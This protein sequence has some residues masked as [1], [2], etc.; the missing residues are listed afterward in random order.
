MAVMN[1]FAPVTESW[2]QTQ[3]WVISKYCCLPEGILF[4]QVSLLNTSFFLLSLANRAVSRSALSVPHAPR[5]SLLLSFPLFC[6]AEAWSS[7]SPLSPC[8]QGVFS[9]LCPKITL[10]PELS[11]CCGQGA[12]S[13]H[14][15]SQMGNDCGVSDTL[16]VWDHLPIA[17]GPTSLPTDRTQKG[18]SF[19]A[20]HSSPCRAVASCF[21]PWNGSVLRKGSSKDVSTGWEI[22]LQGTVPVVGSSSFPAQDAQASVS[23]GG[24]LPAPGKCTKAPATPEFRLIPRNP[25]CRSL[26]QLQPTLCFHHAL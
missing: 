15:L 20:P 23:R 11:H 22:S 3:T 26:S 24:C 16:I 17:G 6:L 2:K 9:V 1:R 14:L 8:S 10:F 4:E 19:N 13:H 12:M 5:Y 18:K 7:P 21:P 25:P